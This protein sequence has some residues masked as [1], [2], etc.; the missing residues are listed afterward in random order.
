MKALVYILLFLTS[1][2]ACQQEEQV[3]FSTQIRP[4]INADYDHHVEAFTMWMA[5][6]GI[7]AGH[8][9]GETDNIGYSAVSGKM[10][11]FQIQANYTQSDGI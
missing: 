3:D 11:A 5:G 4:I 7:K 1:I 6:G 9:Y 8:T 10:S 2:F